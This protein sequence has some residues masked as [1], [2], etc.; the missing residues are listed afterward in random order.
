MSRCRR[1]VQQPEEE[2]YD[3]EEGGARVCRDALSARGPHRR[4]SAVAAAVL[5]L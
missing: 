4:R 2:E 1:R 5:C 3:D